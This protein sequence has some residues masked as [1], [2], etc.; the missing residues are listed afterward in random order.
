[1]LWA[2]NRGWDGAEIM[3]QLCRKLI[4]NVLVSYN[5]LFVN[6]DDDEMVSWIWMEIGM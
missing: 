3:I 4:V 5:Y 1:M 6:E 2:C